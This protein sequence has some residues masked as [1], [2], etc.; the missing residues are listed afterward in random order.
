MKIVATRTVAVKIAFPF[1]V[2]LMLAGLLSACNPIWEVPVLKSV[3]A[4]P[5]ATVAPPA[6]EGATR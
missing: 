6:S 2:M 3:Q 4:T 1:V 5:T